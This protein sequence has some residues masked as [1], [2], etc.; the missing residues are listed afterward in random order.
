[1]TSI[2]PLCFTDYIKLQENSSVI[3]S[4]SGTLMEESALLNLNSILIRN[5]HERPEGM[6][7]TSLI[8]SG[9]KY[10]NIQ[11]SLKVIKQ[12]KYK[13]K[14]P[15]DYD[16]DDFSKKIPKIILSY[17]GYVKYFFKLTNNK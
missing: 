17:F 1:M 9:L 16:V 11:E 7:K 2:K 13:R 8:V 12:N 15:E 10:K 14:I 3:I 5:S 4:D 6:D